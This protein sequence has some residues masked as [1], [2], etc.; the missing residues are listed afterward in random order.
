M[1]AVDRLPPLTPAAPTDGHAL[2]PASP[3]APGPYG[4]AS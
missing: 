1:G 2:R 3:G 4:T